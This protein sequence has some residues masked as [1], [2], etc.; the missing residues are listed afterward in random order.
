MRRTTAIR[1]SIAIGYLVVMARLGTT[2]AS[3]WVLA[4]AWA[5]GPLAPRERLREAVRDAIPFLMFA[6]VY[7]ALGLAR[8]QI[9]AGGVHTYWPYWLDRALFGVRFLGGTLSLNEL[10]ARHHWPGVDFVAGVVYLSFI[11]V[12]ALCAVFL[13]AV[14]RTPGGRRRLR[15]LGWTFLG[16]NVAAF[17]TY[18][19]LP[20]APP[21]YV[22]TH[23]FGP[24]DVHAAASPAALVRWD[25]ML[26]VSYFARFYGQ[27]SD[28]FGAMPSM[29]CAYP[30]LLLLYVAEVRRPRLFA[31]LVVFQA[32]TCFSA[33]YLQHHY[34]LD[35]IVGATYAV[36]GYRIERRLSARVE[37]AVAPVGALA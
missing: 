14:D 21:W 12:V 10:F 28:V 19:I 17:T 15:A 9:A 34:V 8:V 16:M 37:P 25:A 32:L 3:H 31:A 1:V 11:Y 5:I 24:V 13:G 29:H 22:A 2:S 7:D 33:V 6:A 26:G 35:V 23:G 18:V 20:V 36:L 30:M 27:S 4:A